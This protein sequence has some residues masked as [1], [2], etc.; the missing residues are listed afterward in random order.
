MAQKWEDIHEDVQSGIERFK[1][2]LAPRR[3][4][5]KRGLK[6]Y[7]GVYDEDSFQAQ[8]V[9]S[10]LVFGFVHRIIP[11]SLSSQPIPTTPRSLVSS[12]EPKASSP[13]WS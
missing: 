6:Y 10:N 9:V 5:W 2:R 11:A 7:H 1:K 4:R 3:N 8:R 13:A 12:A